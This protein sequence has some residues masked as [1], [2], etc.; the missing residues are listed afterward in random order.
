[1]PPCAAIMLMVA[2]WFQQARNATEAVQRG[3]SALR[4]R[5]T[6]AYLIAALE[7]L[8]AKAIRIGMPPAGRSVTR[9]RG[10]GIWP[11]RSRS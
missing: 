11:G 2:F 6:K 1:M 7:F 8:P 3:R 9:S 5:R 10:S 4:E